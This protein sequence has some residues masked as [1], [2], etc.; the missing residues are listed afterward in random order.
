MNTVHE[1]VL[2]RSAPLKWKSNH[3]SKNGSQGFFLLE[4]CQPKHESHFGLF[5]EIAVSILSGQG[6]CFLLTKSLGPQVFFLLCQP[7]SIV[8]NFYSG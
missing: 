1:S 5:L 3:F 2:C 6:A 8:D 4:R 7:R